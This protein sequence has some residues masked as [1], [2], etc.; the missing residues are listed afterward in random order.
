MLNDGYW[1]FVEGTLLNDGY[2]SFVRGRLL[3]DVI[4]YLLRVQC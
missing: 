4:G 2:W 3:A 1:S